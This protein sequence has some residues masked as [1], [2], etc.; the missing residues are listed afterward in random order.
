MVRIDGDDAGRLEPRPADGLT[1]CPEG[2]DEAPASCEVIGQTLTHYTV[3]DYLGKGGMGVVYR[4]RDERLGREVALKV[5]PEEF[6]QDEIRLLRFEREARMLASLNHANIATIY[7][8]EEIESSCFLALE[9][10]PGESLYERIARG[11][12]PL[13]EA[14]D[15]CR[16][17]AE[18]L[19]AAHESGVIHRDLK[20]ANVR[21]TPEGTV[22]ILDFGLARTIR[23]ESGDENRPTPESRSLELTEE[24]AVLGTPVYMSPEQ[25]HGRKTDRRTDIWSFGCLLY[26]C[27]TG[28]RVFHGR[29]FAEVAFEVLRREPDLSLLPGRTPSAVRALIRRCLVKD[30]RKRQRDMGDVRLLLEQVLVE[31][32]A[33]TESGR[34]PLSRAVRIGLAGAGLAGVVLAT[35]FA[36]RLFQVSARES[37]VRRV[38]MPLANFQSGAEPWLAISPDGECI[39]YVAD[40]RLHIRELSQ[41][42]AREIPA[43][44][45]ARHVFWSPDSRFVGYTVGTKLW[46]VPVEGGA[47]TVILELSRTLDRRSGGASWGVGGQIVFSGANRGQPLVQVSAQGGEPVVLFEPEFPA[48]LHHPSFLPDDRGILLVTHR[49]SGAPDTIAVFH[50]GELKEVFRLEGQRLFRPTYSRSGHLLFSTQ[51]DDA[52]IWAVPFSLEE[53][54]ATGGPFLVLAHGALHSVSATGS[55][56]YAATETVGENELVWIGRDGRVLSRIGQPQMMMNNPRLSPDEEHVSVNVGE[57]GASAPWI[58]SIRRG[59]RTRVPFGGGAGPWFPDGKRITAVAR[60]GEERWAWSVSIEG[61]QEPERLARGSPMDLSADGRF[62]LL[63]REKAL[64][65]QDIWFQD[66]SSAGDPQPLLTSEANERS[67]TISPDNAYVAYTGTTGGRTEVYLTSF[68]DGVGRW[69]VSIAGGE[70]PLWNETGDELFYI[71]AGKLYAVSIRTAPSLEI[72]IPTEL[73]D[74]SSVSVV[75]NAFDISADGQRFVAIRAGSEE[76]VTRI[77]L[78]EGWFEKLPGDG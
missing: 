49:E 71:F 50:D 30:P 55:L 6:V 69:Q 28:A 9:L 43:T 66:L 41:F 38:E 11:R 47:P 26:E 1:V 73:F 77:R 15:V 56:L 20:P 62:L 63:S 40:Q 10:V 2:C 18:G 25:V 74:M 57:R 5:L 37:K 72:G 16:Q 45:G 48:D 32:P 8:I 17:I 54:E 70:G 33:A 65:N 64:L 68:P 67:P 22:K 19:E 7:E 39:A 29:T 14:L 21:I 23:P 76:E 61:T 34:R 3:L 53:L 27:L 12:L 75:R 42:E 24:G 44:D 78:I 4:A 36:P 51:T 31:E 46:K 13:E 59:S 58:H 52:G 60:E 35:S